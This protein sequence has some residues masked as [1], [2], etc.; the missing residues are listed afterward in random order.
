MDAINSFL[1]DEQPRRAV[2]VGGG[3]IGL[4]MAENLRHRGI[5]VTLVEYGDQVMAS[6]DLEMASFLH[7][8]LRENGVDLRLRENVSEFSLK[9]NELVVRLNSE[10]EINCD[11]AILA[12]GVR[13]EV[14]LAKKA[15]LLIGELGGIVV[16]EHMRTNDPNIYAVGD[17]IEVND[18]VSGKKALVPLAGPANRQGRI[19]AD[20]IFGRKSVYK[21]T[22]GTGICKV[23]EQVVGM[24]GMNEKMLKRV[25]MP[26]EK[27][28][29][30][31]LNHAGYYPGATPIHLKLLFDPKNGKILGAQAVGMS[32]VDKR[33]DILAVAIRAGFSTF[34]LESLE[35]CYAPPYGS[36]KDI[37]NYAG[38]VASNVIKGDVKICHVDQLLN[39]DT[40]KQVLLDVRTKE[41]F[42][43]GTIEG[44]LNIP[45]DS[46]REELK[47]FSK[48][49]EFFV[50]CRVGLRG[51]LASRILS[52]SGFKCRNLSGGYLTYLSNRDS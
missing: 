18:F 51:Y 34:D 22:Q 9:S 40:K 42:E 20:N 3:Y 31:S 25:K 29:L 2:V 41:E 35:L 23:F 7:K 39:L 45:V 12:A 33:I 14:Q 15:K 5:S 24:T 17:V 43:A 48:D 6:I 16:D 1:K 36:A 44:A 10:D 27:I 21:K 50:F 19:A 8:E 37:V 13:P 28:Y 26:Y 11:M 52:Q 30:H 4:E 46:L 49:K 38:F 32:G 47:S